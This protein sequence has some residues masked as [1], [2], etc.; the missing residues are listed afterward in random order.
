MVIALAGRRIDAADAKVDRFPTAM[1]ETVRGRLCDLFEDRGA[2][3]LVCS[4]ACGADL[5]ALDAAGEL[6]LRRRMVLPFEPDRFRRTSV[7]DRS[8]AAWWGELFDRIV[9]AL[10]PEDLVVLEDAGESTEAYVAANE[11]ILDEAVTLARDRFQPSSQDASD[12]VLAV[13][14][15]EGSQ[16][17]EDDITAGFARTARGRGMEVVEVSTR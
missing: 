12:H 16:R 9:D 13:I 17:G 11:A 10:P 6:G 7:T 3:A 14:V 2:T 8:D 1:K 4:G 5:L 15:W